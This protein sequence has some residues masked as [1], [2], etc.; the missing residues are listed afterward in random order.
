MSLGWTMALLA[1]GV[2]LAAFCLWHQ[3]RPR[4]IGDVPWFPS[5]LMLGVGVVLVIVALAH[6]V[7]LLTG[8]ELRGR[9]GF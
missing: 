1:G 6:L 4:E 9:G 8:V 3:R 5:T 2:A 7:S